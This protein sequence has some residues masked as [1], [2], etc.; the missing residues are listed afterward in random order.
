MLL[1]NQ[2]KP[3]DIPKRLSKK[4]AIELSV[5][6]WRRIVEILKDKRNEKREFCS[7]RQEPLILTYTNCALCHKYQTDQGQCLRD[8]SL[9]S[10]SHCHSPDSAF[11]DFFSAFDNWERSN[12]SRQQ[13][14]KKAE[15]MLEVLEGLK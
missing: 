6:K 1:K 9:R 15:K 5:E 8:C 11:V 4:K 3:E 14:I 10:I 2:L 7:W 13:V 12:V